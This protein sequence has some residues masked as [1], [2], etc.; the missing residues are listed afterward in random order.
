MIFMRSLKTPNDLAGLLGVKVGFL[1]DVLN[2]ADRHLQ[3]FRIQHPNG[4]GKSRL[5]VSARP[6]LYNLQRAFLLKALLPNFDPSPQSHGGIPGRSIKT[7]AAVHVEQQFVYTTDVSNFF[8]SI[9]HERVR[10]W[11]E[12]SGCSVTVSRM[13]A[14]LCTADGRLQQG[15]MTSPF[16]ADQLMIPVDNQIERACKNLARPLKYSR[17]VDDISIS[18]SFDLQRSR[19]PHLVRRILK[20]NGFRAK[21]EKEQ[22]GALRD[23]TPVTQVRIRNGRFD[24]TKEYAA[25]VMRVIRDH[26]SLAGGGAFTGPFHSQDQLWGKVS[27]I[28]WV[29]PKRQ[30]EMFSLFGR[31]NWEQAFTQACQE[32]FIAGCLPDQGSRENNPPQAQQ[33]GQYDRGRK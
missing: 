20:F 14:R 8:P 26:I 19:I 9:R 13:C 11:F 7:N 32:G 28:C 17:Y 16:I 30:A 15:L 12:R 29:N 1:F 22:F 21:V 25:E 10:A 3:Q 27:F 6:P 5:V 33:R 18:G 2:N 24:V 23:G 31:M 4:T